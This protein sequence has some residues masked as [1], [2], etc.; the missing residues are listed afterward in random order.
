[1]I[2]TYVCISCIQLET[3]TGCTIGVISFSSV[4]QYVVLS[5][6]DQ[7][8]IFLWHETLYEDK[9]Y[10]T[11]IVLINPLLR[12]RVSFVTKS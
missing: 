5:P 4:R 12:L 3:E 2:Y 8:F 11:S 10:Y 9:S 1:M 6:L 7:I